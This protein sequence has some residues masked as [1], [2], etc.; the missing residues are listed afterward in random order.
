MNN[1]LISRADALISEI[2][3]DRPQIHR[4]E[5]EISRRFGTEESS[6]SGA[7]VAALTSGK[8][9][10]YGI[11]SDVARFIADH[12]DV[13]SKTLETGSGLSTL[14]FAVRQ[15]THVCVTPSQ[16]EVDG[17]RDYANRKGINFDRTSFVIDASD[18]YLPTTDINDLD[19]IF[20]DGKHAFPWPIVD[21]FYTVDRL[22]QGGIVM[23]DDTH[24]I[25]GSILVDFMKVDPRW[26][27]LA[28]FNGKT[29]AFRKMTSSVHDVAWHMQPYITNALRG[30]KEF[31]T[32]F[33]RRV[34]RK[35]RRLFRRV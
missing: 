3:R 4:G 1:E 19:F 23:V 32:V 10:C 25:S 33:F 29:V 14:V 24:M 34:L 12:I 5:T 31:E 20:I 15:S 6:L 9:E 21:W 30:K 26:K 2:L 27:L 16:I 17:I 28:D 8:A 22:K 35:M 7:T 13:F 18:K 11:S